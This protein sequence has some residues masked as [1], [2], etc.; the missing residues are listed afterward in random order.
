M[1]IISQGARG[2]WESP[3]SCCGLFRSNSHGLL[4]GFCLE[5]NHGGEIG[6]H[7]KMTLRYVQMNQCASHYADLVLGKKKKKKKGKQAWK[8]QSTAFCNYRSF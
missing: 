5:Q 1:C 7:H 3:A 6:A 8:K 4:K 2:P